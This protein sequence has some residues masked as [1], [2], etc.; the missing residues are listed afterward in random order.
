[1]VITTTVQACIIPFIIKRLYDPSRKYAG[2]Q[3]RNITHLRTND[4]FRVLVCIH[5]P[6]NISSI[7]KLLDASNPSIQTPIA[8]FVLHLIELMGRTTPVFISHQFQ[9]R[10]VS[11]HSLSENVMVAFEQYE[12]S[13]DNYAVSVQNFTAISPP[14]LMHED[15]CTLALNKLTSLIIMPFHRKWAMDGSLESENHSIRSLNCSVLDRAPCS[16]GILI[17]RA[18]LVRLTSLKSS[19]IPIECRVA[20]IFIGGHDDHEAFAYAKR[21]VQ[22]SG[23]SSLTVIRFIAKDP[24][25]VQQ[26]ELMLDAEVLKEVKTN[27]IMGDK[28]VRYREETVFDGP[29]LALRIREMVGEYELMIVGRRHNVQCRQTSGLMEWSEFPELGVVGDLLAST[30]LESRTSVLVVQQ[31]RMASGAKHLLV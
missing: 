16:V 9:T 19:S 21:M 7:I 12:E 18:R 25:V 5:R 22:G 6:D 17:D 26:W 28:P 2:Y 11:D 4:E 1:M 10:T 27:K 30:D 8:V 14:K 15:I 24:G 29:E 31:Q 23:I 20:M 3:Q 13:K